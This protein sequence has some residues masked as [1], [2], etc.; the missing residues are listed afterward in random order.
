MAKSGIR[1]AAGIALL[2]AVAI[3]GRY[4]WAWWLVERRLETTDNA[5]VRGEITPVSPKVPGY[6][7]EL[8]VDDNQTVQ[9]DQVLLRIEDQEYRLAVAEAEAGLEKA[10]AALAN[11]R[12]Q[13]R[14][15]QAVIGQARAGVAAAEAEL[16]RATKELTRA[17]RLLKSG[18]DTRQR[19]D[20]AEAAERTAV[21]V[22]DE[23]RAGLQAAER[24]TGVLES[25]TARLK[26]VVAERQAALDLARTRLADTVVRAP[27]SGVVGNRVVRRGQYVRPGTLLMAVVPLDRVWV[28]AN[29]KETQLTHMRAGQPVRIKVDMFPSV[30]LDGRVASFSPASGAEFSLLP[31]ENATGNF[32]KLVQRIP[33]KI[34]VTGGDDLPGP[35]RPGMSVV[36]TVDTRFGAPA[37]TDRQALQTGN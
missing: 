14:R 11:N 6:V 32:T 30:R 26:A 31:P 4:L 28:E 20:F 24:Q 36:V 10:R 27:V 17:R 22:L 12:A 1:I 2:V 21:A 37:G 25:E 5:Y 18:S 34:A 9:R 7:A 16:A 3:G 15:Q 33:V 35:L 8:L 13:L 29:F 23:R 19:L